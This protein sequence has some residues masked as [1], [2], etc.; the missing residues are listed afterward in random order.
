WRKDSPPSTNHFPMSKG[1]KRTL[2]TCSIAGE[3]A[4][5]GEFR[6]FIVPPFRSGAP[7]YRKTI[8]TAS[9]PSAPRLRGAP[10]DHSCPRGR[11][12]AAQAPYC[13]WNVL[14]PPL[15]RWVRRRPVDARLSSPDEH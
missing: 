11:E 4:S 10:N 9:F 7:D 15:V 12:T 6:P 14:S 13:Q 3:I 2:L 5:S 1:R 8:L